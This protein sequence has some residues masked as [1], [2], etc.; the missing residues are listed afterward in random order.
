ML[1]HCAS[2]LLIPIC[3]LFTSS[4]TTGKIPSQWCTHCITPIHKA[5][6]K[7]LVN[8]YRPISLLCI[9]SKVLERIICN[10][11][12]NHA[13]NTFT[14]SQFGFLPTRS[15]LQQLILFTERLLDAKNNKN[16]VDVIYMDFRKAFD[17]VSHNALLSK[18]HALGI[19][20]TLWSWLETYLKTRMQCVRI[21]NEYSDLRKVL[22][23]VPQGSIL[24]PLLFGIFINDLPS[25]VVYSTPYLFADDTKCLN[26]IC[27]PA[28]IVD[29]QS[30]LD[31]VSSWSLKW[32]LFFNEN[33]FVHIRF[34]STNSVS[35]ASYRIGG[36]EIERKTHHKDL[37]VIYNNNLIWTEHYDYII[38]KA[39]NTLGLLRRTFKN[40][41]IQAKKQL[42]I[43]LV[44]SQLLYC[45]QIW[46]PQLIKDIIKLER[47]QRRATK[48]ILNN[49]DL[50]YKQRLQQLH[51]LPLMYTYE[52]NDLMLLIKTLKFPSTHFD[53]GKYIQF[54]NHSTRAASTHKLSHRR[55]ISSCYHNSY[56]N[57]II[58]LWNC[59]PVIDLSLSLDTLKTQFTNYM[60]SRF[61][62]NFSDSPCTFHLLC[63]CHK[64]SKLPIIP[65]YQSLSNLTYYN[66]HT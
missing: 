51:M 33:K 9:I 34:N 55:A 24:G 60:W 3:H 59:L 57:R 64:C 10:R 65:N 40:N 52:L 38:V 44:R 46:R 36:R 26:A 54:S 28:D 15:A 12:I 37:G 63:P 2:A 4:I 41:N 43:S 48:Y 27:S 5:G 7:T 11:I 13:M 21:G 14:P 19:S 6:S 17:S 62:D 35:T 30:D 25:S 61:N 49:Y 53:I 8:N 29:L 20:G 31:G 45:S 39:Y 42:Y 18:L 56:F 47:I 16:D 23:G 50:S 58:R 66:R 32:K 1:R 22:S